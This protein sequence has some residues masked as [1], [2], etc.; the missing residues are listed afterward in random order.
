M[1]TR[2]SDKFLGMSAGHYTFGLLKFSVYFA[3]LGKTLHGAKYPMHVQTKCGCVIVVSTLFLGACGG[4]SD[5]GTPGDGTLPPDNTS[6]DT[7][8]FYNDVTGAPAVYFNGYVPV[9]SQTPQGSVTTDKVYTYDM[10]ARRITMTETNSLTPGTTTQIYT[11]DD[12]GRPATRNER[13][14]NFAIQLDIALPELRYSYDAEGLLQGYTSH[15]VND[16]GTSEVAGTTVDIEWSDVG[17]ISRLITTPAAGSD[18]ITST[19]TYTYDCTTLR[20][21]TVD[22]D[23]RNQTVNPQNYTTQT[24]GTGKAVTTTTTLL[25]SGLSG[26]RLVF[27]GSGNLVDARG[28]TINYE[29]IADQ[30]VNIVLFENALRYKG[31]I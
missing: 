11:L 20:T 17:G 5:S 2:G 19:T 16:N 21:A 22:S 12:A 6:C 13:V 14:V 10:D 27:D 4:S 30:V 31:L 25:D 3:N 1:E 9:S 24:S 18:L 29:E 26:Q 28:E 7:R 8:E 23:Y 15:A